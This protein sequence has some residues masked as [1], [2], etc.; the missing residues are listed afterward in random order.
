MVALYSCI[1]IFLIMNEVHTSIENC[2]YFFLELCIH[3]FYAL[4]FFW[5]VSIF[6]IDL[7]ELFI[8]QINWP[9]SIVRFQ[10]IFSKFILK[11]LIPCGAF[12]INIF[13]LI[14]CSLIYA[15]FLFSS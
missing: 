7:Y 11:L 4:F 12:A 10:S 13:F 8:Y 2:I 14:Y 5:N 3:V 6:V 1:S 15:S 9:L